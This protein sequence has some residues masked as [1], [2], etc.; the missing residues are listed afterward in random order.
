MQEIDDVLRRA[1]RCVKEKLL[2]EEG[3]T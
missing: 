1:R 2:L 3:W